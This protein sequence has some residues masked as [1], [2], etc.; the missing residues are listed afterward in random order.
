MERVLPGE[1][2]PE[3]AEALGGEQAREHAE[4]EAQARRG[5]GGRMYLSQLW[6][7]RCPS[8]GITLQPAE[9]PY[10]RETTDEKVEPIYTRPQKGESE[11][12][13]L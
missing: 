3:Q 11:E 9:L 6:S 7:Y 4:W 13:D 10:V 12:D 1:V 5:P 8:G 2:D